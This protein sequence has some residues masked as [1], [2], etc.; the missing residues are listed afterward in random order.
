[1][2][3]AANVVERAAGFDLSPAMI[4]RARALAQ[5]LPNVEFHQGDASG[6]LPFED[7]RFTAI[8]CTTAFHHSPIRKR[9]STS[10]PACLPR[11]A[12]S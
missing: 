10:W 1:M 9:R 5:G 2:R 4:A 7:D 12:V 11:R 6:R 3:E 8:L